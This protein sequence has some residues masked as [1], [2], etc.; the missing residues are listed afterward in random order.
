MKELCA[1]RRK[2][3]VLWILGE[4]HKKEQF[5][6]NSQ[7]HQSNYPKII[8]KGIFK[9]MNTANMNIKFLTVIHQ[10]SPTFS[11]KEI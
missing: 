11:N 10:K 2:L 8:L 9:M 6:P 1:K 4:I 5:T 7:V 3:L